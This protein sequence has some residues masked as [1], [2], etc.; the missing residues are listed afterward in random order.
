MFFSNYQ[1]HKDARIRKSL[2]WEYEFEKINL[3]EMRYLVV[4][5][6]IERGRMDDYY[7]MLNLY[8][9]ESV[10]EAIKNIPYMNSKD[11]AFV[12]SVFQINKT[13]L[14]CFSRKQLTNPH[15]NS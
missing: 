3:Q 8:G 4:Q 10:I 14:K 12:C 9:I 1:Q 15:W 2:F 11:Q 13:D 7:A 6:V 5:R